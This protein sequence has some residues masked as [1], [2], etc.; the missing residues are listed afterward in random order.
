M[1]FRYAIGVAMLG[2]AALVTPVLA[3]GT[4]SVSIISPAAGSAP[5]TS[6][7]I[8]VTVATKNYKLE[9]ADAGKAAKRGQG[10]IHAM[11]DGMSMAQMTNLYCTKNFKFSGAGL[12]PGQH[13]LAVIL[14]SN[15]HVNVGR[16]AMV[17][18]DYQPNSRVALPAP[19]SEGKPALKVI[20]PQP[21]AVVGRKFNLTV[22]I[23]QFNLS[24][25]LAGKPNVA[26]YGH[27]HLFVN[28]GGKSMGMMSSDMGSMKS[29]HMGGE[30]KGEKSEMKGEHGGKTAME[31]MAMPGLVSMP[32]TK[33]IPVDL[34]DW[35]AGKTQLLVMLANND[36]TPTA[37]VAPAAV[38]VI[39]K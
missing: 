22:A 9:C 36:H 14:A 35:K 20:S 12:K 1:R 11:I 6:A 21:G 19:E 25:D 26:G 29:Q 2:A 18:F 32:C 17:K 13:T 38:N 30:M 39:V 5:I 3:A 24:C 15:D 4:T 37:G 10:H 7:D 23:S 28:Q 31:S 8:P 16:P 33:T 27:L 34:S